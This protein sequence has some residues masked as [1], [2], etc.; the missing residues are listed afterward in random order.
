M[1]QHCYW[2]IDNEKINIYNLKFQFLEIY[3]ETKF[4]KVW[5]DHLETKV[6]IFR[7]KLRNQ[8]SKVPKVPT[9]RNIL[10]NQSSK[11]PKVWLDPLETKVPKFP[12]LPK[13]DSI[14]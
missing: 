8:C 5:F 7:N 3:L 4:P 1:E 9:F 14:T 2:G 11:V 10:R 12:K 6:S 13:F